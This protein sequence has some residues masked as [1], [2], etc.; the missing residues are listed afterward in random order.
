M[1]GLAVSLKPKLLIAD[2]PTTAIDSITQHEILNAFLEIK[3]QHNTAMIFISHDLGAIS[4][5]ADKIIVMNK[6]QIVDRGDFHHILHHAKDS[7]TRL[8]IEKR[9]AVLN[10]YQK[11]LGGTV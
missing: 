11:V 1:I 9:N 8:L 4:K 2:E 7:Y 5:V 10:R 6:G 3:E